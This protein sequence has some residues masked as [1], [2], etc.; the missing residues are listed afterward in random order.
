MVGTRAGFKAHF[1]SDFCFS[2]ISSS[3]ETPAGVNLFKFSNTVTCLFLY[4]LQQKLI[5]LF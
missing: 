4:Y 3:A 1:N 2:L 5:D